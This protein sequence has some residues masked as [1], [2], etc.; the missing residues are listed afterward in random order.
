MTRVLEITD[1]T[2]HFGAVRAVDGVSLH[3]DEGEILGL[4]GESGSGK[5]TVGRLAVRLDDPTSGTIAFR[6]DDITDVSPRRLRARRRDFNLVFQDPSSSL[7]PRM[8][9][10]EIVAEPLVHHKIGLAAERRDR[11][12]DLV[13]RVGLRPEVVD[14]YP[15]QL[16]GGMRQRISLARALVTDPSL[17]VADEPTS[18]LD[19]SVQ[20]AVLNLLTDLQREMGFASLFISHD[21]LAVEYL[22]DRVAVMYL[23]T[24]VETG[25]TADLI[26]GPL[27]PY[28]QALLSAAP[29]PDVGEQRTRERIQISGDLPS[30]ADPPPG[31]RFHT[32][33]PIAV[34]RCRTQVPALREF[35]RR[36]VACHLVSDDGVA[37]SMTG[38]PATSDQE[39]R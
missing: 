12:R 39:D 35:G 6:G 25:P 16:S 33:C 38:T 34:D 18:A 21:L 20:A 8:T 22:A 26:A 5:S 13:T 36:T 30:P 27:H 1:L 28:T 31:C 9:C 32:R 15:H 14:L 23:G 4:V 17:V 37:P 10:G 3:V 2:R 11:V 19:V 7:D 29:V 24:I